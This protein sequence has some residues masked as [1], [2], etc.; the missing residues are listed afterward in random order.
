MTA[1]DAKRTSRL[2]DAVRERIRYRHFSDR[3]EEVYLG[4]E[5]RYIGFHGRRHPREMGAP[6]IEAFLNHLANERSFAASTRNQALSSL[7]FP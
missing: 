6:E 2:L 7:L 3:T 4:W 5:R 1:S